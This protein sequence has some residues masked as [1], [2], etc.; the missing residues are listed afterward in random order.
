MEISDD[1]EQIVYERGLTRREQAKKERYILE[2]GR[3]MN[4][5]GELLFDPNKP[6]LDEVPTLDGV[7]KDYFIEVYEKYNTL[8]LENEDYCPYE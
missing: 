3:E 1:R 5:L 7:P 2:S 4:G 6:I 8:D